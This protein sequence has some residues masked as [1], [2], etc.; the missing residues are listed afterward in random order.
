VDPDG[1]GVS[2]SLAAT[3]MMMVVVEPLQRSLSFSISQTVTVTAATDLRLG[4]G[5]NY[6]SLGTLS[7]GAQGTVQNHINNLNGVLAKGSYW[8]KLLANGS[9]GWVKEEALQGGSPPPEPPRPFS[10]FL[11][12]L[13]RSLAPAGPAIYLEKR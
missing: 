5:T 2:E 11:P 1:D 6:A 7:P 10:L 9:T 13:D 8:W 12:T 3:G 4:P